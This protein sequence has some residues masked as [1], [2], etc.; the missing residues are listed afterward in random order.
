MQLT[1]ST[2]YIHMYIADEEVICSNKIEIVEQLTNVNTIVLNNCYP[3]IWEQDK[4]YKKY[5]MPKDYS[6]FL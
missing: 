6:L 4:D 5:Y 2:N 1:P 3:L